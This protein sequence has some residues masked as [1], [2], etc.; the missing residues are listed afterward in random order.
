M[1]EELADEW[2][3]LGWVEGGDWEPA[4][5]FL[6]SVGGGG[7]VVKAIDDSDVMVMVIEVLAMVG[8]DGQE[9][10]VG[11]LEGGFFKEL[12]VERLEGRF[13]EFYT[14]TG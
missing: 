7:D 1:S 5:F 6:G 8:K 11:G 3:D 12:A 9:G 4:G 10:G 14:T 2:G 13:G